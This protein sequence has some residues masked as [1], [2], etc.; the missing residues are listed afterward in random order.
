[1]NK[2]KILLTLSL[3]ILL[4]ACG[5]KP[6][7]PGSLEPDHSISEPVESDSKEPDHSISEPVETGRREPGTAFPRAVNVEGQIAQIKRGD[8]SNVTNLPDYRYAALEGLG[9]MDE[10]SSMEWVECELNENGLRGL[11]LQEKDSS[12]LKINRI[13]MIFAVKDHEAG[14]VASV[15]GRQGTE[16]YFLSK[17]GNIIY[18]YSFYGT[19]SSDNFTHY[20][21]HDDW[22]EEP[23]NQLNVVRTENWAIA[24]LKE[25]GLFEETVKQQPYWA[26]AGVYYYLNYYL[27]GYEESLDEPQFLKIFEEMTG[28]SF[29]EDNPMKPD[30]LGWAN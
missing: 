29:Y 17:S 22:S 19:E 4:S 21:Y 28:Y 30:W 5:R 16:Q 6:A 13:E 18:H 20:I 7:A 10:D 26:E 15:Y 11:I 25:A 14:L 9:D 8:L 3:L 12:P 2:T 27:N 1:M 23:V 24:E